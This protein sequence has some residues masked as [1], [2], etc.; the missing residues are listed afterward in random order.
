MNFIFIFGPQAVGKMTIGRKLSEK[1]DYKFLHN[2]M[3][4]EF[5]LNF[6]PYGSPGFS[7][8]DNCIRMSIF[9]E[10]SKVEELGFIF[11][12]TWALNLDSEEDYVKNIINIFEKHNANIYFIELEADLSIRLKRNKMEDRI[13]EK[14]SKKDTEKSEELILHYENKYQFNTKS[15][16]DF[17]LSNN[18]HISYFKINTNTLNQDETLNT[19]LNM[20]NPVN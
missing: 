18:E 11:T 4:I 14:P 15:S 20:L 3:S 9:E 12:Y 5:A 7:R 16:D 10:I 19:V 17:I 1:L 8:L 13:I 6:F 2:H